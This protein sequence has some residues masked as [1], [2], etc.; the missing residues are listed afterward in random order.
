MFKQ[1]MEH[2]IKLGYPVVTLQEGLQK[3]KTGDLPKGAT[4]IT[5]DDG[6]FSTYRYMLPI[7]EQLKLPATLYVTT[8]FALKGTPI[9]QVAL[10]Y[11]LKES[12][13]THL[14]YS[15]LSLDLHGRVELGDS[16]NRE[17]I[18]AQIND[19]ASRLDNNQR[20]TLCSEIGDRLNIDYQQLAK[21]RVLDLMTTEELHDAFERGLD[22]QLHTHR[23]RISADGKS[24]LSKE[25]DENRE[26]LEAITKSR[27]N[28]FCYPSGI[29]AK[30]YWPELKDLGIESA[31]TC[32]AGI[33][34][35]GTHKYDLNRVL[36]SEDKTNLDFEAELSGF[37]DALRALKSRLPFFSK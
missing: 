3:L 23:H 36:D 17:T 24:T 11:M 10:R 9:T 30:D 12:N 1:R 14:D 8:Y 5:I 32:N 19:A 37:S 25:V 13:E 35:A 7:F 34:Y 28:H 21:S 16:Q 2:L 15:D 33:N 26:V 22:L 18:A 20:Q 27:L 4:V 6:W 31:T 29:Y